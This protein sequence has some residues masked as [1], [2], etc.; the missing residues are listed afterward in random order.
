[1][2]NEDKLSITGEE[3]FIWWRGVLQ[4]WSTPEEYCYFEVP[5][6]RVVERSTLNEDKFFRIWFQTQLWEPKIMQFTPEENLYSGNNL[7]F[8]TL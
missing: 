1:M 3:Y 6:S 8:T 7:D 2:K 5:L 4:I